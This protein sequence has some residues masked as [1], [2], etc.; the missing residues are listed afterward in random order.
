VINES[1]TLNWTVSGGTY[2]NT[3]N[4]MIGDDSMFFEGTSSGTMTSRSKTR[5]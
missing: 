1:G 4:S 3:K 5:R 2:S